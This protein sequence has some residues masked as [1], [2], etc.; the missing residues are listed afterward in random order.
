MENDFNSITKLLKE[1]LDASGTTNLNNIEKQIQILS[2]KITAQ[3]DDSENGN[4]KISQEKLEELKI[5]IE[6]ISDKNQENKE[7]FLEFKNFLE[8]RKIK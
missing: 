5:L 1:V 6:K 8:N 3:L 4:L 2:A 7:F